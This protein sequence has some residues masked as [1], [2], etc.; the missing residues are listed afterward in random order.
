[1]MQIYIFLLHVS[2]AKLHDVDIFNT[3]Y[4]LIKEDMSSL[5]T[6][7][8]DSSNNAWGEL[9]TPEVHYYFTFYNREKKCIGITTIDSE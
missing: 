8:N 5:L 4:S 2:Y 9:G 3:T 1:M 7:L 6:I